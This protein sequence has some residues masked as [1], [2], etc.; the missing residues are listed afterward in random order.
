M[1]GK[2]KFGVF[3][4]FSHALLILND[5]DMFLLLHVFKCIFTEQVTSALCEVQLIH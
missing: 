4:L 2:T 1:L 3:A 5:S